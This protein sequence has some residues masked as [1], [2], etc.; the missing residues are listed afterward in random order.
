MNK[1]NTPDSNASN[2]QCLEAWADSGCFI[3]LGTKNRPLKVYY[4]DI[5]TPSASAGNTLLILHGFPESS[6]SFHRVLDG[7]AQHFERV[8]VFDMPGYGLSDK[9]DNNVYSYSLIDQADTAL[10]LWKKLGIG[11]G[12]ILS[13]DM[14]TSVATEIAYRDAM[15]LLPEWIND[16]MKSYT[17][18]NGSM[19]L[20]HADLRIMQKVL[21]SPLGKY[22]GNLSRYPLF[23]KQILSAH[24]TR[25]NDANCVNDH[26]IQMLWAFQQHNDGSKITHHIIRYLDDRKRFQDTRWLPALAKLDE[27]KPINL[28]WGDADNVARIV[29]P[30][31]LHQRVCPNSTLTVMPNVGHFCQLG[32]PDIWLR[33][34]LALYND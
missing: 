13:H 31:E 17:F 16:G 12:H 3:D 19:M 22:V 28:C 32:S 9:P 27:T 21:L 5:G 24:G 26:D 25:E 7:L 14:G 1:N 18:T 6:Y 33:S 11:G 23:K 10:R 29:M 20:E 2:K 4:Q 15:Q 30:H 8:V 34:I